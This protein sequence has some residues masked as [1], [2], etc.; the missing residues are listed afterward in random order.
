[1]DAPV[2][3]DVVEPTAVALLRDLQRD[4]FDVELMPDGALSIA[5]RSRLT[6][7]RM[8]TI[9]THKDALKRLLVALR[10]TGVTVRRDVFA[11]QLAR[12]PAPHVPPFLFTPGIVYAKGTCFSCGDP[13]PELTFSRCWRC[14]FAWRLA[15]QVPIP[16]D[17]AT[18]LDSA[19]VVA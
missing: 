18:A 13:L 15:C 8:V 6:P 11:D 1:M 5:P 3:S 12:T 17:L 16:A 19:K 10:E 7:Q 9:A 4:G 2:I 14:S